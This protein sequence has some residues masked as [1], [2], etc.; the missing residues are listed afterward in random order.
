MASPKLYQIERIIECH[1]P[2]RQFEILKVAEQS[3]RDLLEGLAREIS[4]R[5]A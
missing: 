5:S 1:L 4:E 2:K 3:E